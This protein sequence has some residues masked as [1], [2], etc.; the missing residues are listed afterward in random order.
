MEHTEMKHSRATVWR[1]VI[2]GVVPLVTET[3]PYMGQVLSDGTSTHNRLW[4]RSQFR[5]DRNTDE[6]FEALAVGNIPGKYKKQLLQLCAPE[7][8]IEN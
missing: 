1:A 3:A 7:S 4:R 5:C 2:K 8:I 6:A